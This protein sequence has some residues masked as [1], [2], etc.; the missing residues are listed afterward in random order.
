MRGFQRPAQGGGG[1]AGTG[2]GGGGG[3]PGGPGGCTQAHP[4]VINQIK[5]V[6]ASKILRTSF[7]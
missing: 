3:N 4:A 5:A 1:G 2:I 7:I 6:I